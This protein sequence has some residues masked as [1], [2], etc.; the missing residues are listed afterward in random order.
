MFWVDAYL[1]VQPEDYLVIQYWESPQ[2]PTDSGQIWIVRSDYDDLESELDS[3]SEIIDTLGEL[4]TYE[5]SQFSCGHTA[6]DW[7]STVS[8][9]H[10][11]VCG[12]FV[13][14]QLDRAPA[15]PF[16]TVMFKSHVSLPTEPI[17]L[18]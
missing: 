12:L 6:D 3:N 15:L 13:S 1:P 10:A 7:T 11:F 17:T 14:H 8:T 2:A 18:V 9:A 4:P 16:T 5:N